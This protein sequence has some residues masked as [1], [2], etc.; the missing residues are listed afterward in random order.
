VRRLS[1]RRE[2]TVG[3]VDGRFAEHWTG[4]LTRLTSRV[5]N[6]VAVQ[7]NPDRLV[8]GVQIARLWATANYKRISE[9]AILG[10]IVHSPIWRPHTYSTNIGCPSPKWL[11][12]AME[13]PVSM[14]RYGAGHRS[15]VIF[16]QH[17]RRPSGPPRALTRGRLSG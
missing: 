3:V 14:T 5:V 15:C 8:G 9:I 12:G 7:R 10:L 16:C 17:P 13:A 11:Y 1:S 2:R 6:P 4:T